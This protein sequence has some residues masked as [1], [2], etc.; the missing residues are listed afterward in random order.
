MSLM[1]DSVNSMLRS[2]EQRID[3]E[4]GIADIRVDE[5]MRNLS[6]DIISRACFGSSYSQ[7]KEIF[8]MLRTLQGIMSKSSLFIGIPGVR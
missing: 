1:V 4:G 8:L 3:N 5:D 7:G 2:W 6:A